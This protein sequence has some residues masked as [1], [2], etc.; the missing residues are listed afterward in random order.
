MELNRQV[1]GKHAFRKSLAGDDSGKRSS[2]SLA[3]FDVFSA[4]LARYSGAPNTVLANAARLREVVRSLFGN[5]QFVNAITYATAAFRSVQARFTIA[6]D[7]LK[8]VLGDPPA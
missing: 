8:E 5:M 3:L 2:F 6:E 1:F 7:A 4:T